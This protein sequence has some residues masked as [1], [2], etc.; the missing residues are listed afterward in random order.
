ML[1]KIAIIVAGGSGIRMN[2]SVPKQF[3]LL[4]DKPVIYYSIDAFLNAYEDLTIILVL[5][6]EYIE[7][8]AEIINQYF[9][10]N[11][12]TITEGGVT[13]FHSVKNGLKFVKEASIV[14]VQ[15]G[16]RCFVSKALIQRCYEAALKNGTAIPAITSSD[17]VRIVEEGKTKSLN[18]KNILLIQTPQTFKSN[19]ILSAFNT[20][21]NEGFTDEASVVEANHQLVHI[22]E[23]DEKNIKITTQADLAFAA[24]YLNQ[25]QNT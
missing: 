18:R 1:K 14:F 10:T 9:D 25:I 8:G 6:K 19:I 22:V 21:Y 13:R 12:I 23:G 7:N 4:G 24:F 16:V 17:S 5:P 2:S 3:M 11:R 15:D 20:D